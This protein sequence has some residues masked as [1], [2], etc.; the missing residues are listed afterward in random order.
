M[1]A[2]PSFPA[3][4]SRILITLAAGLGAL[5]HV[6]ARPDLSALH[7]L[8][9][10]VN[11]G[12]LENLYRAEIRE[13]GFTPEWQEAL[14]AV[15]TDPEATLEGRQMACR[16][17]ALGADGEAA[18]ALEPLL[19]DP[20]LSDDARLVLAGIPASAASTVLLDALPMASGEMQRGIIEALVMRGDPQAVPALLDL[21]T[22]S[23]DASTVGIALRA[24]GALGGPDAAGFFTSVAWPQGPGTSALRADYAL[25]TA[26]LLDPLDPF[27]SPTQAGD[28]AERLR[29]AGNPLPWRAAGLRVSL[30]LSPASVDLLLPLLASSD[31]AEQDLAATALPL[32][33]SEPKVID[34]LVEAAAAFPPRAQALVLH[35]LTHRRDEAVRP[36][37]RDRL[38]AAEEEL[39]LAALGALAAVG[40][41]EDF[42]A[43]LELTGQSGPIGDAAR[44]ALARLPDRAADERLM[45]AFEEA[46]GE[47]QVTLVEV[48]AA[49]GLRNEVDPLLAAALNADY[50]LAAAIYRAVGE[51]GEADKLPELLARID[52]AGRREQGAIERAVV[53]IGRRYPNGE[54]TT[55]LIA[56]WD[57]ATEAQRDSLLRM[58]G[59]IADATALEFLLPFVEREDPHPLALRFFTAWRDNSVFPHLERLVHRPGYPESAQRAVWGAMR[60]LA[61]EALTNWSEDRIEMWEATY[62]AAPDAAGRRSII[63][64]VADWPRAEMAEWLATRLDDPEQGEAVRAM[65]AEVLRRL[66]ED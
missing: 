66:G 54:V 58:V 9:Y 29:A 10:R 23:H 48:I 61:R 15:A 34:Q 11:G 13:S 35:G 18:A 2:I 4:W 6:T 47:R 62:L 43:L 16:L 31:P 21:A 60:R 53:G 38:G 5:P 45:N 7:A 12:G 49:R 24:A 33:G 42:P 44:D 36:L 50:A 59:A 37:A 25:A 27:L 56:R 14:L 57:A 19:H 30:R 28:L 32:L 51:L 64:E 65:H 26:A 17:L 55:R 46:T 40:T 1:R 8:D 41:A 39:Q 20:D 3:A 52:T 63:D 22:R